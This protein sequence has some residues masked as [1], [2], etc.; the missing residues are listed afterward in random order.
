[1][2]GHKGDK[3]GDVREGHWGVVREGHSEDMTLGSRPGGYEEG[4]FQQREQKH[5]IGISMHCSE[6][7]P[8]L[9]RRKERRDRCKE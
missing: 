2:K 1:M 8:S 4:S 3:W 9:K 6:A 5:S 7:I